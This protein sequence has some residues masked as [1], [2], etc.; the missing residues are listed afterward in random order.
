[1]FN[2]KSTYFYCIFLFFLLSTNSV[3]AGRCTGSR[4]CGACSTCSSCQYCNS[5]GSC[6]VCG[7]GSGFG[8]FLLIGGGI[9]FMIWLF[10]DNSKGNKK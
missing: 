9:L 7:G 1:M 10:G 2:K 5:G 8:K 6:G 4:N 3:S